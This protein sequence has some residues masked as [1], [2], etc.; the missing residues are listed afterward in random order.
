[1]YYYS[2]RLGGVRQYPPYARL[3]GLLPSVVR[4]R[5]CVTYHHLLETPVMYSHILVSTASRGTT[6]QVLLHRPTHPHTTISFSRLTFAAASQPPPGGCCR[7]LTQHV[8]RH[9]M[10]DR[11]PAFYQGPKPFQLTAAL[12]DVNGRPV[13]TG[14]GPVDGPAWLDAT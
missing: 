1:M 7:S 6:V 4:G 13:F 14:S 10:Y 11:A 12:A 2:I 5:T 3:A 9:M 8:S